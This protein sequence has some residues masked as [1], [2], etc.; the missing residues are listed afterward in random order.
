MNHWVLTGDTLRRV[1]KAK[2]AP[3][4]VRKPTK[5]VDSMTKNSAEEVQLGLVAHDIWGIIMELD[6]DGRRLLEDDAQKKRQR[7]NEKKRSK[8]EA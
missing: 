4:L 6:R 2:G 3:K 1:R 7:E 8:S 5:M